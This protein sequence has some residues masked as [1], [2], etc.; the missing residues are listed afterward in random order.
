MGHHEAHITEDDKKLIKEALRKVFARSMA[1][2]QA[3]EA[4][5]VSHTD[6]SRP[7]VKT[8]CLCPICNRHMAKSQMEVDH[9]DPVIP[10]SRSL[11]EMSVAELISRV[12]CT[13][14][15]LMALCE[16]C[17]RTKTLAENRE[18]RRVKKAKSIR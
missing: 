6:E 1:R 10:L 15:N 3:I 4:T 7:R 12:W 2:R 17:H 18:R 16:D 14:D 5:V 13:S 9:I 11:A 8:W